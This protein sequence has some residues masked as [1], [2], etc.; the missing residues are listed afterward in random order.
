LKRSIESA[1]QDRI[2]RKAAEEA[3][4]ESELSY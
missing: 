2:E 4:R 3:L 1:E